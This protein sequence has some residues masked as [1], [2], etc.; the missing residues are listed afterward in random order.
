M[1]RMPSRTMP[2]VCQRGERVPG[3][4]GKGLLVYVGLLG[5]E[6]GVGRTL[7]FGLILLAGFL[8]VPGQVTAQMKR[9]L[10]E[11]QEGVDVI[12]RTGVDLPLDLVFT[13]DRGQRRVLFDLF[14][15]KRPVLLSLNYS[16]CPM[17]CSIQW[18]NMTNT[19]KSMGFQPKRDFQIVSISLDPNET[20]AKARESKAKYVALYDLPE[21]A[22]GWHF[23]VGEY[24]NIKKVADTIGFRYKRIA[25][26][27]F[28]HPPLVVLCSPGGKVVRYIHGLEVDAGVLDQALIEAS[29]GKI[30]SPINRFLFACY[31][32][33][34]MTGQY[35]PNAMF[36]MKVGGAGMV[37]LVV[38][39]LLPYWLG[40]RQPLAGEPPRQVEW[41]GSDLERA[42]WEWQDP[43]SAAV[44]ADWEVAER[45]DTKRECN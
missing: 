5:P 7:L 28:V 37:I 26:G 19:L 9:Q 25:N 15:G 21:T 31:Q 13:D 36:L 41:E 44:G 23:L 35:T 16:D 6:F 3:R 2:K 8:L 30:G 10:I 14:D 42:E 4:S 1:N 40:R 29:E 20:P 12:E 38:A 45:D 22:D 27:H 24:E 33:N 18:Q 34:T 43:Q 11:D 32:F 39:C 17:L